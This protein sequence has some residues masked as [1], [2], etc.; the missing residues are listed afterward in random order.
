MYAVILL[1]D[2]SYVIRE[3]WL[4]ATPGDLG[5][6]FGGKYQA[7]FDS[8]SKAN[9]FIEN[10]LREAAPNQA[11]LAGVLGPLKLHR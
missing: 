4:R 3:T 11:M 10:N 9:A 8:K 1:E 5:K 2:T 7:R 6:R